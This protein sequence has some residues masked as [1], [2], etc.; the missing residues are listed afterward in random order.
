M[1]VRGLQGEGRGALASQNRIEHAPAREP[2]GRLDLALLVALAHRRHLE[3]RYQLGQQL[4]IKE[5]GT[6]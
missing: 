2:L 5:A 6:T 3:Q 4:S 1:V